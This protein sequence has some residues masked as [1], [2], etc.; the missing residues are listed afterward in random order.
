MQAGN[1]VKIRQ[2]ARGLEAGVR[3]VVWSVDDAL[4]TV[5]VAVETPEPAPLLIPFSPEVLDVVEPGDAGPIHGGN[6]SLP[7]NRR[8]TS[9]RPSRDSRRTRFSN[10]SRA[11]IRS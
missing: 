8:G 5:T 4:G 7:E 11:V 2:P 3:G 9:M 1:I 6:L 10:E